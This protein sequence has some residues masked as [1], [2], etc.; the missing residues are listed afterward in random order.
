MYIFI[1]EYILIDIEETDVESL[2]EGSA[3]DLTSLG[4][5]SYFD[6]NFSSSKT[7]SLPFTVQDAGVTVSRKCRQV[8]YQCLCLG[9]FLT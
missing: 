3:D 9:V 4:D 6:F 5:G 1:S 2:S 8:C 7:D